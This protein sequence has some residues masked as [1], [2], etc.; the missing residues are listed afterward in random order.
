[1]RLLLAA[2]GI[3][4]ALA[5]CPSIPPYTPPQT[6]NADDVRVYGAL[7]EAGCLASDEGGAI[8]LDQ[9]HA[10]VDQPAWVA[11]MYDGGSVQACGAPCE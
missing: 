7:V 10:R 3:V 5:A 4:C 1:M 6:P 11:C 9:V 2:A 8:V